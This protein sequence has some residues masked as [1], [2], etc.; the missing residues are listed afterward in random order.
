MVV[1]PTSKLRLAAASCSVIAVFCA[2]TV[3]SAP[4]FTEGRPETERGNDKVVIV[5]TDGENTYSTVNPDPAGNKSTYAA[6]GYTGVG[7]NGTSVTRLFGGTRLLARRDVR[8]H[9]ADILRG[10]RLR[11]FVLCWPVL[12]AVIV[13]AS[14]LLYVPG[15]SW[16]WWSAIGGVGSPVLGMT[17]RDSG[18]AFEWVIPLVFVLM[19]LPA[20]PLF[21]EA[22]ERRAG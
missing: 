2:R 11:H 1:V 8:D 4:P 15:L 12:I 22:E 17:E 20:L 5:L 13:V 9:I 6:Y 19:L 21:A 18:S 14:A 16:G 10:L 7:Y 3:S